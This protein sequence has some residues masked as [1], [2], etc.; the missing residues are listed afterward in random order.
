MATVIFT[1]EGRPLTIQCTTDEKMKDICN[2]YASK[3]NFDINSLIFIYSGNQINF[4]LA[5]K[6]QANTLDKERNTMNVIVDKKNEEI[7]KCPKCGENIILDC[8]K[9]NVIKNEHI[10]ILK[11]I[12]FQL[13]SLINLNNINI[14]KNQIKAANMALDGIISEAENNIKENINVNKFDTK[15]DFDQD[16]V[17]AWL[18]N[19]KFKS[20]LLF[21]KS[22]D[23]TTPDDFHN[24]C[25][26]KGVTITFIETTKGYKFGGYT[27]LQWDRSL[28][29]KADQSTFVFSFNHKQKYTA[30]N[31]NATMRCYPTDG[32]TFG[33][34]LP[35]IYISHTMNRG[36]SFQ[37]P[38]N[39]F[40]T[41][42][43]FTNGE[44]FWDI[45]ELEVHKIIY[46]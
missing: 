43:Q 12:K 27:E 44:E 14:I 8:L 9:E 22:R 23:G 31:N 40:V 36:Q 39:T 34:A 24:R 45:K 41:N 46:L 7:L 37:N 18:N 11:G 26:N 35:Q 6:E 17:L 29:Q 42:R 20:E 33:D 21:R 13:E 32:P 5:F 10:D 38:Q 1:F 2:K 15:I 3:I 16:L 25:D 4:E 19:R 28:T 30:R